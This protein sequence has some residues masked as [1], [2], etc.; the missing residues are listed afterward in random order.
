M[1][2]TIYPRPLSG[3]VNAPSSKSIMHRVLICASFS[4]GNTVIEN[5]LYCYDTIITMNA[6][7][8]IGVT[9]KK[10]NDRLTIIPPKSYKL[11][12]DTIECGNSG[13]TARFLMPLFTKLFNCVVFKGDKRL[14]ERLDTEDLTEIPFEFL[15]HDEAITLSNINN[16]NNI[17]IHNKNT[18]QLISGVLLLI[19]IVHQKGTIHLIC[20][21]N[22][23]DP[24]IEL[25]LDVLS[26]FGIKYEIIN[27]DNLFTIKINK[28]LNKIYDIFESSSLKSCHYYIEGDYSSAA[29]MLALGVLGENI[30]VKNLYQTSKQGDKEFIN[31]LK[32]MNAEFQI[33]IDAIRAMNSQ[34]IGTEI[35]LSHT[36][37]LGPLLMGLATV[38]YGKTTIKN[39]KRLGLK[40]SNRISKTIEILT[41][42]G[43]DIQIHDNEIKINGKQNLQ[44][45]VVIDPCNDH[46]L[47][48][49]VVALSSKY[50]ERV[51]ILNIECVNKSYP[52]FWDDYRKLKGVALIST[53]DESMGKN[54]D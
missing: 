44:G 24:Y 33:G 28:H 16:V 29:N 11:S 49:M 22:I 27:Q 10:D 37:D 6:L 12:K 31:I 1:N 19:A 23:L 13:S 15:F 48:M 52:N 5:P 9:F 45:G 21:D 54:H 38:A 14:I 25:T 53:P 36:P 42:L 3:V 18:S 47:L 43:A 4:E 26:N 50:L 41:S 40:E 7:E 34:L 17:T 8:S 2:Y 46:R 51:T 20:D 32:S 30:V 35:D 39:F